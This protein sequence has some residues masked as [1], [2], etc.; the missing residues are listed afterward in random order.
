MEV[1]LLLVFFQTNKVNTFVNQS[2]N[3]PFCSVPENISSSHYTVLFCNC[4]IGDSESDLIYRLVLE[5]DKFV[6]MLLMLSG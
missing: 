3:V 1:I 4:N 5:L 6:L 2:R